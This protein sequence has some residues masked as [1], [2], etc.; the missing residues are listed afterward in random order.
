MKKLFLLL[1]IPIVCL[2]QNDFRKMN[3]GESPKLL[4]ERYSD[5]SFQKEIE[6]E[7]T[8]LS[9][10]E[11][12]GG[13]QTTVAYSF[14]G[15][16]FFAGVYLFGYESYSKDS[17]DRLK[18]FSSV[19]A[20][21]NKKYQMTREDVWINDSYKD[22]P[23]QLDFALYLAHVSLIE[24]GTNDDT[25]IQHSLEKSEGELLHRLMYSSANIMKQ[26][27]DSIDDDF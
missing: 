17:K 2:S 27:Q 18:D 1:F 19:S 21:L 12:V 3:W 11:T 25:V 24:K 10:K 8:I 5:I 9:H 26:I 23:N 15:D 20:R 22:N 7:M 14:T 13:I 6:G 4:K 16:K